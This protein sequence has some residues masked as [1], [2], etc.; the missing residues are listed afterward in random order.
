MYF[1]DDDTIGSFQSQVICIYKQTCKRKQV[2]NKHMFFEIKKICNTQFLM[3]NFY[4]V[5]CAYFMNKNQIEMFWW[6]NE[7]VCRI[8]IDEKQIN[9]YQ[10]KDSDGDDNGEE[11][12]QKNSDIGG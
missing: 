4:I 10:S 12:C 5:F 11:S 6:S 3:W 7:G 9:D 1:S 2:K 8:Y